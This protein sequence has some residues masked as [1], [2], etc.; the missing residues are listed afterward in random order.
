MKVSVILP[1]A[2]LGTRMKVA[3]AD[4][5][6]TG[7]KQFLLLEGEPGRWIRHAGEGFELPSPDAD[8]LLRGSGRGD[9]LSV[10]RVPVEVEGEAVGTLAVDLGPGREPAE[11]DLA[12][13]AATA[14]QMSTSKPV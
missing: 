14:R 11:G 3:S 9:P 13:T 12:A 2:G 4:S 1:A 8:P 6:G 10:I 7:R 5:A